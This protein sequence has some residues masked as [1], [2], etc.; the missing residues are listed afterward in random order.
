MKSQEYKPQAIYVVGNAVFKRL[1]PARE[2]M[3]AMGMPGV[4]LMLTADIIR[5][6]RRHDDPHRSEVR[7]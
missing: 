7:R 3:K 6:V 1:R 2:A 4:R 5:P